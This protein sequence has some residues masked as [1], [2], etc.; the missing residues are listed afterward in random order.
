MATGAEHSHE[1]HWMSTTR[2][3]VSGVLV[4]CLVIFIA[5]NLEKV[6]IDFLFFSIETS[7]LVA[8]AICAALGAAAALFYTRGRGRA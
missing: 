1:R 6:T 8:M 2:L 7:M 3:V 4:L 5:Q